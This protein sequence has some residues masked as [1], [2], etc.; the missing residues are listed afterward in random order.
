MPR[1]SY[2]PSNRQ[3]EM[4]VV[5]TTVENPQQMNDNDQEE[6]DTDDDVDDV[7]GCEAYPPD[8]ERVLKDTDEETGTSSMGHSRPRLEIRD[9]PNMKQ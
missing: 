6:E 8:Q 7:R 9:R 2:K 5:K 1:K 3:R 4:N